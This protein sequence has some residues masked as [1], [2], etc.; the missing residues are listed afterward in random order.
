MSPDERRYGEAEI[1][2]IFARAAEEVAAAS[3]GETAAPPSRRDGL[4]LAELQTV[5]A[6]VGLAPARIAAAAAALAPRIAPERGSSYGHPT[7]LAAA[8]A[9]PRAPTD[10]E[11]ER[12]VAVLRE[13]AGTPGR[14]ASRGATREWSG[15]RLHLFVEPSDAGTRLRMMETRRAPVLMPAVGAFALADGLFLLVTR[16]LD[17]ST[18]GPLL[19]WLLP[20]LLMLAGGAA[21][22]ASLVRARSWADEGAARMERIA[23]RARGLVAGPES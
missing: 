9:L 17:A 3:P 8:V 11:W 13:D 14:V 1:E 21:V 10:R 20:V 22:A 12:L 7:S 19:E 18:F 6:E 2:E 23:E 5:G 16:A 15:G 4:T